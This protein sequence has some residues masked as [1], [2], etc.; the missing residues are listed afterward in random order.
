MLG[1]VP[2]DDLPALYASALCFVY[3]SEYEGFGLQ[4]CEAMSLG[5]PVLAARAGSLPE[6]L[7]S[8]GETFGLETTSELE[9]LLRVVAQNPKH[10]AALQR[11]AKDRIG[12]FSWT[13]AAQKTIA[14]YREA[15]KTQ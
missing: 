8:G 13:A 14:V 5:C 3:P 9:T 10:R 4:L 12:E 11:R 6:V 7:G 15:M 2:E 1:W